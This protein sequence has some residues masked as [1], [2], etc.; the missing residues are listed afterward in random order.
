VL[1]APPQASQ[2]LLAWADRHRWWLCAGALLLYVAAFN[3]QWRIGKDSAVHVAIARA[4]VAGEGFVHPTG[5]EIEVNPGLAYLIA[6]AFAALGEARG[7]AAV[8]AA[9]TLIGLG[10]L[11]LTFVLVRMR[12]DRPTAVVVTFMLAVAKTWFRNSFFLL[13]DIPFAVGGLATLVGIEVVA[14]RRGGW[15]VVRGGGLIVAGIVVMAAFRSVF[16]TFMAGLIVALA[17]QALMLR[18]RWRGLA[19]GGGVLVA[20]VIAG[21]WRSLGGVST[22]EDVI[23]TALRDNFAATLTEAATRTVPK[24]VGEIATEAVIGIDWGWVVGIPISVFILVSGL[25]LAR[26][27]VLW[28]VLVAVFSLQWSLF[29]VTERYLLPILPLLALGWWR[30]S[31]WLSVRAGRGWVLGVMMGL[32]LLPNLYKAGSF[33]VD[34]RRTPFVEHYMRGRYAPWQAAATWI[35]QHTPRDCVIVMDDAHSAEVM[36]MADRPAIVFRRLD[37]YAA[38]GTTVVMIEPIEDRARHQLVRRGWTLGE[39]VWSEVDRH[40]V[41]WQVR[42]LTPTPG[43]APAPGSNPAPESV[44]APGSNTAPVSGS[45]PL[46]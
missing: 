16:V 24:F 41:T 45:L 22:D 35:R 27:R 34:Q 3:G 42:R 29:L 13:T 17:W 38:A 21:M 25:M 1:D 12:F 7:M 31:V 32:F 26:V 8:N 20:L 10:G 46:Q 6:G 9:I 33:I 39:V 37:E 14:R 40:G 28:G 36:V 44:P 4:I 19:I 5:R 11:G 15:D 23:L 2:R 43:R 18:G 30:G